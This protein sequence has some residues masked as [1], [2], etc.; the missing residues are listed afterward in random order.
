M[1]GQL[2]NETVLSPETLPNNT[3][4]V[5]KISNMI[6]VEAKLDQQLEM[7]GILLPLM[8]ITHGRLNN[9]PIEYFASNY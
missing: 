3:P 1:N 6:M 7:Y 2:N 9:F 8:R 4:R 5:V